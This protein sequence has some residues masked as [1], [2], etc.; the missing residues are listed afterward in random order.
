MLRDVERDEAL[1]SEVRGKAA[2]IFQT[3]FAR[4]VD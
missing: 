2:E 3:S 1:V 4:A